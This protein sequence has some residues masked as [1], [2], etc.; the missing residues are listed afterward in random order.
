[1]LSPSVALAIFVAACSCHS[2]TN[3]FAPAVVHTSSPHA[4]PLTHSQKELQQ[5]IHQTAPARKEKTATTKTRRKKQK[6][7]TNNSRLMVTLTPPSSSQQQSPSRKRYP[8]LLTHPQE[9]DYAYRIRSYMAALRLRDSLVTDSNGYWVHP[10]EEEWAAVA[11]TSVEQLQRLLHEGR[12]ARSAL[13]A[14]NTGLV[15]RIAQKHHA[16]LTTSVDTQSMGT[17]L[18]LSDLIQEGTMGLVTAAEKYCPDRGCRFSTYATY[19]IRQRVRR[20]V[21]QS[22]RSIRLPEHV[23]TVLRGIRTMQ[24]SYILRHGQ[25]PSIDRIARAVELPVAKVQWYLEQTRNV[26]SLEKP[27]GYANS[28][29]GADNTFTLLETLVSEFPTPE[30]DLMTESL[31]RDVQRVVATSL[32]DDERAVVT[33]R[34]GLSDEDGKAHS[35][36][37]T[38]Q[39][40][41]WSR[42]RVR[43]V[44]AKALAS[45]REHHY[46]LREY[47]VSS[48]SSS[49]SV[50][51]PLSPPQQVAGE[52]QNNGKGR[53]SQQ[54]SRQGE[55]SSSPTQN[56]AAPDRMWFF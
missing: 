49:S 30:D 21:L 54:E 28:K 51:S 22:S 36:S 56:R 19:W 53:S 5:L 7:T 8:A 43:R 31:Q 10:T 13:I 4:P 20:S 11:G 12:T 32:S 3:A 9:I 42:D 27:V 26:L 55:Q 6:K 52:K 40:L 16:A 50:S 48:S 2:V 38:A 46:Q 17:I 15:I 45:L 35:T 47:V 37:A 34:Y 1:M 41:G 33:L 44:E 39:R 23:H 24:R 18:T 25:P 29:N 14:A